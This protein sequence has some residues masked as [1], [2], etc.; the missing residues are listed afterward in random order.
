MIHLT[1]FSIYFGI[2][3]YVRECVKSGVTGVICGV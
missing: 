2:I 1:F 3:L